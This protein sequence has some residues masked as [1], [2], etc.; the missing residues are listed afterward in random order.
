MAET[1][2]VFLGWDNACLARA[3]DYLLANYQTNKS[4]GLQNLVVA[5]PGRRA[6]RRLTEILVAKTKK[7][8]LVLF[9]PKKMLT[10]GE[11]PELLY[12][13]SAPFASNIERI[14]TFTTAIEQ[15]EKSLLSKLTPKLNNDWGFRDYFL[16]SKLID[17]IWQQISSVGLRFEDALQK[18]SE[19]APESEQ[20][21]WEVLAS[22]F[23]SYENL[24]RKKNLSDKN[25]ERIKALLEHR[26]NYDGEIV[27]INTIDLF[28][29]AA[30]LLN[31][32][33]AQITSL[34]HAPESAAAG[35]EELGQINKNFWLEQTISVE[36]KNIA[37]VTGPE[38]QADKVLEL[39]AETA[40][41]FSVEDSCVA[42]LEPEFTPYLVQ[43]L[44]SVGVKSQVA[45]GRE[46][47]AASPV[48]LLR[49]VASFISS[50]R[51]TELA[52]LL[53]HVDFENYLINEVS[54]I[55]ASTNLLALLDKYQTEHVPE[56]AL[57]IPAKLSKDETLLLE[58]FST[59]H[60][61]FTPLF[62]ASETLA[63]WAVELASF[64]EVI[65]RSRHY[66]RYNEA[67]QLTLEACELIANLL[68]KLIEEKELT[69]KFSAPDAIEL[70]LSELATTKIAYPVTEGMELVGWLELQLDDSTA[71]IVTGFNEGN[72]PESVNADPF[73][74]GA[75]CERLGLP[76]NAHRLARDKFILQTL[77]SS[78]SELKFIAPKQS[79]KGESRLLS[80]LLLCDTPEVVAKR[81][82]RFFEHKH[83][84]AFT[85]DSKTSLSGIKLPP[86][87]QS[88][89]RP[90]TEM[91]VTSFKDYLACPYRFYLKHALQL[92]RI[93]DNAKELDALRFGSLIHKV[94][95]VFAK[96]EFKNSSDQSALSGFLI[97]TLEDISL[98]L[99]GNNELPV[100]TLQ[101]EQLKE[102][103]VAFSAWQVAWVLD[104][105]EILHSEFSSDPKLAFLTLTDGSKMGLRGRIDR[106]DYNKRLDTYAVFD[107]KS[108]ETA[109]DPFKAHFKANSWSD[110]QLPL[111]AEI[112]R[113]QGF[114]ERNVKLGYIHLS[115]DLSTIGHSFAEWDESLISE[116]VN[117]AREIAYLVKTETFWPPAGFLFQDD[118]YAEICA[119]GSL[120]GTSIDSDLDPEDSAEVYE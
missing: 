29:L 28:G 25:S 119:V 116:A 73:L 74:P 16:L 43:H 14:L 112:L 94:M 79:A 34:I 90:F 3:A 67:E 22:I 56:L 37:I 31:Q 33:N 24:L 111:Y 105:W 55:T 80:R 70:I 117:Q 1:K 41:N 48:K 58:L 49:L 23:S 50:K 19:L 66:R 87:P 4:L 7:E 57:K 40:P 78:K 75:L 113:K 77:L 11:L 30:S 45:S 39:L 64:F 96:S 110:L 51:F 109:N 12:S 92:E 63:H 13:P 103:L 26:A 65:Y 10:F 38:Q 101:L 18:V 44:S 84:T 5:L 69:A 76:D 35:F 46:I 93:N 85:S 62:K 102:R 9:L 106:I 60:K 42:V 71:L 91:S 2:R 114:A 17:T 47:S 108:S 53:R 59:V 98:K 89:E 52:A 68:G 83:Q 118:P 72:A 86:E 27:L 61:L 21:R 6:I 20:V 97:N 107:Y 104:G 54:G 81:V 82:L 99:F 15:Q 88:L 115:S 32:S 95:E 100:V 120:S 36:E 8:S